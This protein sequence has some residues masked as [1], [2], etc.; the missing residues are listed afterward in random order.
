[1]RLTQVS[2][3]TFIGI[4]LLG[5]ELGPAPLPLALPVFWSGQFFWRHIW[6]L[7]ENVYRIKLNLGFR[8]VRVN[9]QAATAF[10]VC[11]LVFV[12]IFNDVVHF[13]TAST[14]TYKIRTNELFA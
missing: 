3:Q 7:F 12:V 10:A 5:Q 14:C 11:D 8:S 6:V 9:S 2:R 4:D 1:M 13:S